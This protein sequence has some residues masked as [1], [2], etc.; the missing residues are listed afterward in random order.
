MCILV[1]LICCLACDLFLYL[2]PFFIFLFLSSLSFFWFFFFFQAED[3]IRDVA[4]TGVQTCALPI[5]DR[6]GFPADRVRRLLPAARRERRRPG[7]CLGDDLPP[8]GGGAL[9][10]AARPVSEIG[11]ASCRERG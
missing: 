2:F 6:P 4:V 9:F 11:R 1:V 8:D 5:Y 7:D 3:G 10:P